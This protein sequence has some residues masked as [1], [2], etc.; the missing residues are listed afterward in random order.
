LWHAFFLPVFLIV[1][2]VIKT[3]SRGPVFFRQKR[4]GEGGKAFSIYKF[5]TMHSDISE[6][7]HKEYV[8][9]L[10]KKTGQPENGIYKI[11]KDPRVTKVGRFLRK[12][13]L[14]EI[15]QFINVLKGD[16]SLVGP[17]P[18][19]PY[20]IAEYEAWHLRR[21]MECKPGI[22][23]L[24]QVEGRSKTD[25]AGMVRMDLEYI[26]RQSLWLD[27]KIIIKTPWALLTTRGA[28]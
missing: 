27:I 6:T 21:V 19:I 15:P 4:I 7:I 10:I 20:E 3:D 13:S 23:G 22:T 8:T 12:T 24:W 16:M 25:F 9:G 1:P 11:Q 18:A 17:R 2:L 14:D 26:Q 5:R 28:Y